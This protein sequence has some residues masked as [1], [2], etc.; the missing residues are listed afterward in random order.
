MTSTELYV[1][2]SSK[3]N[4]HFLSTSFQALAFTFPLKWLPESTSLYEITVF[5]LSG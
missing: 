5:R 1:L 3:L 4:N 2:F